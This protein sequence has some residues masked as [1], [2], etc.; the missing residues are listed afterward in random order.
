M[1]AADV[2]VVI[3]SYDTVALLRR[4]LA[5]LRAARGAVL[6]VIVVDNGSRDGSPDMVRTEFPEVELVDSGANKG[7]AWGTNRGLERASGRHFVWLNSDC[8]VGESSLAD[9]ARYLDAHPGVG[10]AGPTLVHT[11]GRLQPSA[12]A[13]PSPA[14]LLVR[15]LGVRAIVRSPLVRA[16]AR[17]FAPL[18]GRMAVEYVNAFEA[19]TQPRAVDWVT[20]ACLASPAEF[21]RRVGPLDEGYFM[22]CEDADWCRRVREAGA[23]VHFVPGVRV[24]HH[25]GGSGGGSPFVNYQHHRSLV[26]WFLR[27]EPGAFRRWSGAIAALF[28]AKAIAADVR[29]AFGGPEHSWWRLRAFCL[30]GA[31][32]ADPLA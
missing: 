12:Q 19:G 10:A 16:L 30:S 26:R 31:V 2:S 29:R 14:R 15:E 4:C 22:Y 1:P 8:E 21:A 9:L 18:F 20:G 13:F 28:G 6:Q 7:F 23:E 5:S 17:P 32:P 25:V 3:V 11:D 24:V 27:W